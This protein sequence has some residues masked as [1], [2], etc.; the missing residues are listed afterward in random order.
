MAIRLIIFNIS[1]Y[2]DS[3]YRDTYQEIILG[4]TIVGVIF[5]QCRCSMCLALSLV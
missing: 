4:F 2:Y 1:K 3:D 5:W